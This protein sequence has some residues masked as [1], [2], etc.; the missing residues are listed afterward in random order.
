MSSKRQ[1]AYRRNGCSSAR[2][3]AGRAASRRGVSWD[4]RSPPGDSCGSSSPRPAPP[5]ARRGASRAHAWRLRTRREAAGLRRE[6]RLR[7]RR[8]AAPHLHRVRT[9]IEWVEFNGH[10]T[11][12]GSF[13]R[14][15]QAG[16]VTMTTESS[17]NGAKTL[18]AVNFS[19]CKGRVTIFS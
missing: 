3:V 6:R 14:R 15:S 8:H 7:P 9:V 19:G 11:Q 10:P 12:Y 17:E 4:V 18:S 16:R 2:T 1:H 5:S 13:R